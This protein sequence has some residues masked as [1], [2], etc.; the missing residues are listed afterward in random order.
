MEKNDGYRRAYKLVFIEEMENG[1]DDIASCFSN[2]EYNKDRRHC[3][4]IGPW[5]ADRIAASHPVCPHTLSSH[6]RKKWTD[7]VNGRSDVALP[8]DIFPARI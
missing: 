1:L 8:D 5:A 7:S 4:S 6:R 3:N 2:A